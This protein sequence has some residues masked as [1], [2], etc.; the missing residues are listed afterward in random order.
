MQHY[1]AYD[2]R[3]TELCERALVTV[4]GNA[5]FWGRHLYLVG[6]L[7]AGYLTRAAPKGAPPHVGS[8]DVDLAIFLAVVEAADASYETLVRNLRDSG[9]TQA[10]LEDDPDYRWRRDVEGT[11]VVIEFLGENSDV[12]P[13][14]MFKPKGGAGSVF[15]A[16]NVPGLS[17]VA[18][19]HQLVPITAERLDTGGR[20]TVSIR[21]TQRLPFV[22]LKTFA[23]RDRHH[24]KDAYDLVYVLQNQTDGPAGAGRS[25]AE[26]AVAAEPIVAQALGELAERFAEPANDAPTDYGVFMNPGSDPDVAARFRN[27]AVAVVFATLRMFNAV[28]ANP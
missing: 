22:V 3:V 14:R 19:D 8:R 15:Q 9:F 10:P 2:P 16:F 26:S 27:E 4:I 24:A 23:Y 12:D 18:A 11:S 13:G 6:G 7:A 5:G 28:R 17:L 1:S 25:M 20:S 21:V